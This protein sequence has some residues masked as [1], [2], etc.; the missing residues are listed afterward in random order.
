MHDFICEWY[1]FSS[2]YRYNAEAILYTGENSSQS[3]DLTPCYSEIC[4]ISRNHSLFRYQYKN[5]CSYEYVI[6][7]TLMP[8]HWYNFTTLYCLWEPVCPS[9]NI[10]WFFAYTKVFFCSFCRSNQI[11]IQSIL[12]HHYWI[13]FVV[14]GCNRLKQK[15][16]TCWYLNTFR[17]SRD[18]SLV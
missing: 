12:L 4:S 11:V 17:D 2:P 18:D 16:I 3:K 1:F 13:L 7:G 8:N 10:M 15:S 5:V 9:P 6:S 14:S